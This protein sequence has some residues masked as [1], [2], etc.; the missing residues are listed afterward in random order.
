MV[1]Q[2]W[3]SG[4]FGRMRQRVQR[5]RIASSRLR[6]SRLSDV[7]A[8]VERFEPRIVLSAISAMND[9]YSVQSMMGSSTP[10][11]LDV[12]ANDTGGTGSLSISS[13]GTVPYG[14]LS[15]QQPQTQ[16]GHQ[17]LLFT[18]MMGYSGTES[19]TYTATDNAGDYGTAMVTVSVSNSFGSSAP[20]ISALSS[21]VGSTL[22]GGTPITINGSGFNS[23]SAVLFGNSLAASYTVNSS[24]SIT[25]VAPAHSAGTVDVTIVTS[26]GST[27]TS[28]NDQ[29]TFQAPVGLPSVST[30]SPGT[31]TTS[32]GT[33]IV[34]TGSNFNNVT[35]ISFGGTPAASFTVNSSTSISAVTP[36]HVSGQVDV[37]VTTTSGTSAIT[38]SDQLIFT[39]PVL[40]PAVTGLSTSSGPTAGGNSITILGTN[41]TNAT[42]VKFGTVSAT[43]FVVNSSSSITV[44]VPA[45]VAD[46]VDITVTNQAGTSGWSSADQYS[47]QSSVP[48][49]TGLSATSGYTTGGTSVAI[50]GTN[51]STVTAV[52]FGTVPAKS[53][54]ATSPTS[55]TAIAPAEGVGLVD[56]TLQSSSGKSAITAADKFAYVAPPPT[57]TAVS[58]SSGPLTGG[59][60][61]IISGSLLSSAT[62]VLFGAIPASSFS[63]N[64][65]GTITATSPAESAGVVDIRVTNNNGTSP[66]VAADQFHFTTAVPVTPPGGPTSLNPQ[67]LPV[68]DGL[69]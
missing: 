2:N 67:G 36:M 11:V 9:S 46:T 53:F 49:V 31:A 20:Q 68:I 22:G 39:T 44:V 50:V 58:V 8:T 17:T 25:A 5:R 28:M 55:L 69:D 61:V 16:G 43:S 66:A 63:I 54:I 23:V 56:I 52:L 37:Q 26:M 57:V 48:T 18:P 29:Y 24:S 47:Y 1:L 13:V 7:A 40:P 10:T 51:M 45:G 64:A 34:I 35:G 15:V 3:L 12:L 32:G 19:F 59:T 14:T 65:N 62:R 30:V 41:F 21:H 38:A 6:I 33:T 4:L 42:G 27:S 60:P